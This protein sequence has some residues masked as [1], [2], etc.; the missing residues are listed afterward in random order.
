MKAGVIRMHNEGIW[1]FWAERY[2]RLWVQKYS[3]SP[4]RRRIVTRLKGIIADKNVKYRILDSGCG[5]GQLLRDIRDEFDGYTLELKGIDYSAGMIA[6]AGRKS[7]SIAYE[8]SGIEEYRGDGKS[9]DI[10]VC[11]HSFP[12][13]KDKPAVIQKFSRLLAEG[14]CLIM[15]QASQNSLYDS[16]VMP[17]VKLTTSSA[18]YPGV[19]AVVKMLE[20]DFKGIETEHIKERFFMPSIYMFTGFKK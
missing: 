20:A 11:S 18:S 19:R 14:G 2:E 6:E 16:I 3:L 12:Y 13:Y 17:F 8:V 9:Y 1:D 10:I 7:A 15:A 5:T 4:T